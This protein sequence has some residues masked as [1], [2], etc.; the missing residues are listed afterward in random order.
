VPTFVSL[1]GGRVLP[2]IFASVTGHGEPCA[3]KSFASATCGLHH[4]PVAVW[5]ISLVF[6]GS[7][8]MFISANITT[9]REGRLILRQTIRIRRNPRKGPLYVTMYQHVPLAHAIFV[10]SSECSPFHV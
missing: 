3:P 2:T 7:T 10:S 4:L 8:F 6:S 1:G 9:D 5:Q